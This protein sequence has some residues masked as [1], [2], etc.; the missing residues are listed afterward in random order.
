MRAFSGFSLPILEHIEQHR[1]TGA[2]GTAPPGREA[3][4]EHLREA[5][6]ELIEEEVRSVLRRTR[7][8]AGYASAEL[9]VQW[10]ATT[11]V[12]VLN[13]WVESDTPVP[14]REVDE[15]F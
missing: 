13:W 5:I 11:F 6:I 4:H 8:P 12:L 14:A 2:A 3:M 10:I 9:L 15:L 1:R 7:R